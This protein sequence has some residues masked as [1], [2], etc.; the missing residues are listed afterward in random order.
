MTWLV[1]MHVLLADDK[2]EADRVLSFG[3]LKKC[4]GKN[5][6]HRQEKYQPNAEASHQVTSSKEMTHKTFERNGA[7]LIDKVHQ[8]LQ[9]RRHETRHDISQER[10]SHR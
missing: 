9:S 7:A 8:K 6:D 2:L 5:Q 10:S 1:Y 3:T 4:E